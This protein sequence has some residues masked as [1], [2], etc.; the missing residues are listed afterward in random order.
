MKCQKE[1]LQPKLA[2][3]NLVCLIKSQK[4]NIAQFM[5]DEKEK[6]QILLFDKLEPE[7]S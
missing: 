5:I 3:S 6:Q 1:I 2:S 7:K 4:P